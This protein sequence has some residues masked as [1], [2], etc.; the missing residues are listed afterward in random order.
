MRACGGR[1]RKRIDDGRKQAAPC[2]P[3][4]RPTNHTILPANCQPRGYTDLH[5]HHLIRCPQEGVK[6]LRHSCT[7]SLDLPFWIYPSGSTPQDLPIWIYPSGS[8]PQDP[9]APLTSAACRRALRQSCTASLALKE[10][11]CRPLSRSARRWASSD[12]SLSR[13]ESLMSCDMRQNQHGEFFTFHALW[14][15]VRLV[16]STGRMEGVWGVADG[17]HADR[18]LVWLSEICMVSSIIPT[19]MH[20]K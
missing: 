12:F 5:I 6:P 4:L 7:T 2:L 3:N 18:G 14:T 10:S 20:K 19:G 11:S 13:C 1:G 9:S 8:S 15:G 17:M 16:C